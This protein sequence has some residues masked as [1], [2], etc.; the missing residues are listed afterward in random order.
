[1]SI[2]EYSIRFDDDL[3]KGADKF[4]E[5]YGKNLTRGG[6]TYENKILSIG[7]INNA[8]IILYAGS[9]V[10][11]LMIIGLEELTKSIEKEIVSKGIELYKH[12]KV[13]IK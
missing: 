11:N 10:P 7:E 4:K 12:G 6:L 9:S 1:M 13:K 3:N 5:I 2:R 8:A